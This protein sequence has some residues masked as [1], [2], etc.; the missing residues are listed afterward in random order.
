MQ[1]LARPI[2]STTERDRCPK[3]NANQGLTL[4]ECL[5]A[6][7]VIALT[8]AMIGPPLVLAAATR[9]Q[10]RRVEQAI[11]LAQGEIDR[12]RT[13]VTRSEHARNVLPGV[14]GAANLDAQ[15]APTAQLGLME[16]VNSS[17]PSAYGEAPVPVNQALPI[18]MDGDCETDFLMQVFRDAG[19]F[20]TQEA[21]R[22]NT[23]RPNTFNMMVRVYAANAS[24]NFGNLGTEPASLRFTSGEGNQRERP[25]AVITSEMSWSEA[26]GSLFCYHND[27]NCDD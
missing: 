20:S 26:D 1:N 22:G 24:Q 15:A 27:G 8:S 5:V 11:Q 4:M 18:D 19:E 17:C 14:T 6:I 7:S 3:H 9:L 13:M 16:S 12:V 23:G 2:F 10:N 25:L 21:N